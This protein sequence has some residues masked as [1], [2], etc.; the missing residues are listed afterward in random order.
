MKMQQLNCY[1]PRD[2]VYGI[3]ALVNWNE[4][5]PIIPNYTISLFQLTT[6]VLEKLAELQDITLRHHQVNQGSSKSILPT[7][8]ALSATLGLISASQEFKGAMRLRKER[9]LLP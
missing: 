3:L 2:R 9:E 7:V 8:R 6:Q 5:D 4:L 1:D